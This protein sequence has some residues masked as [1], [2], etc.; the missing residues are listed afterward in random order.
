MGGGQKRGRTQRRHFR[1][2]RENVWK[3]NRPERTT[4][5]SPSVVNADGNTGWETF[6]TQNVAFEQYYKEQGIVREEEWDEFIGVL[7][8][9]LPAAFRI[10]SSGQFY[11]DIRSQLENDFVSSL[12]V[13]ESATSEGEKEAIRPLPWYPENLAWHLNYSRMQLRKN[14]TLERFHEFLKQENE[15][16]NITRQEA[17]SMVIANDVDVQRCNL[18]IH[19]TKRMCSANLIVTNH[20]AQQFPSCHLSG[21]E[22]IRRDRLLFDRVLCDVPCSGDGTLRKAPDIWRKC[23]S[24]KHIANDVFTFRNVGMGNGLHRLQVLRRS[25]GSVELLDVTAELPELIRRPGLKKWQVRDKGQWL[26]SYRDVPQYRKD[27]I[28]PSMFPSG[29]ICA[30]V[31]SV[32]GGLRE[33][34]GTCE[35]V[36]GVE[37]LVSLKTRHQEGISFEQASINDNE[38]TAIKVEEPAEKCACQ[39]D[40]KITCK[41]EVSEF[42][43]E[44]CVRIVPHDQNTGAFFIAVFHKLAPLQEKQT[45][46]RTFANRRHNLLENLSGDIIK[47]ECSTGISTLQGSTGENLDMDE[48]VPNLTSPPGDS[49]IE[50][51]EVSLENEVSANKNVMKETDKCTAGENGVKGVKGGKGRLQIQGK[52]RGVDPV[53]FFRDELTINSIRTFYGISECFPLDDHLVTRNSDAQHVKRIYYVSD[54]VRDVLNLNFQVGQQLKIT[55]LGLKIFERQTLRADS[56]SCAYRISSEGLPLLLPYISKQILSASL[57]DFEHL[58]KY[59]TIKFADFV[60]ADFGEKASM[61]KLGCCVILLKQDHQPELVSGKVD[62]STIAIGCWRGKTNVSVMVSQMDCQELLDRISARLGRERSTAPQIINNE[63]C[64]AVADENIEDRVPEEDSE[65]DKPEAA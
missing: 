60:D 6:A 8:K 22:E 46:G 42:P 40:C 65:D 17:V 24:F 37:S 11:Q 62:A 55:S 5:S 44:R 12:E 58:L 18:L 10:N 14:Q 31:K 30:E 57:A 29:Q 64:T 38:E 19:Q 27:G 39:V 43:L 45:S 28:F 21:S 61:L 52:W 23:D 9:P 56:S 15:I 36:S 1:N 33:N 16:G 32:S 63:S 59:K 26:T 4:S 3:K 53:V 13:E 7:Q 20:E 54:S 41:E 25:D 35:A 2:G 49:S 34:L 48:A 50:Q 51:M 47:D